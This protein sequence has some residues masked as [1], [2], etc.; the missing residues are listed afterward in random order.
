MVDFLKSIG[1][2]LLVVCKEIDVYIVDRLLEVVWWESFWFVKD[3]VVIME[4]I[5]E[6]ICM[7][8]GI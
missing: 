6:V 1:M 5:D 8:F 2:F 3:G 4:E 7:V